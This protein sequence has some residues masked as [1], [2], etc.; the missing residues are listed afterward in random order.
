MKKIILLLP[1]LIILFA[2]P[3]EEDKDSRPYDGIWSMFGLAT[4]VFNSGSYDLTITFAQERG[5][6]TDVDSDTIDMKKTHAGFTGQTLVTLSEA[7]QTTQRWDWNISGTTLTLTDPN[8]VEDQ[9]I[10]TKQ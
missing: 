5:T 7:E 2:C 9:Q 3:V 8:G 10:Y 6:V 1:V 4:L